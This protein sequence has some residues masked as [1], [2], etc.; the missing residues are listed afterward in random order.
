MKMSLFKK[1]YLKRFIQK[2]WKWEM[3]EKWENE[4]NKEE[5]KGTIERKRSTKEE[6]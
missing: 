3:D 5:N 1:I 4:S 2:F 6:N